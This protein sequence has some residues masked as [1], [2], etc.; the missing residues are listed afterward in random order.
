MHAYS[1]TINLF[2][3]KRKRK[4]HVFAK[5]MDSRKSPYS[6]AA[7]ARVQ[8]VRPNP[9]IFREGLSKP[10]ILGISNDSYILYHFTCSSLEQVK[11]P[12]IQNP[13]A[14]PAT[15]AF[16]HVYS[17]IWKCIEPRPKILAGYNFRMR[18][19]MPVMQRCQNKLGII[20]ITNF[21]G[22]DVFCAK[23]CVEL[24]KMSIC[25]LLKYLDQTGNE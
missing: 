8:G 24:R 7:L 9:S 20:I 25:F 5:E 17:H 6:G 19:T 22:L 16:N 14:A 10:S 12:S 3:E 11:N 18:W 15:I 21:K 13:C 4:Y 23:S 1:L 2:L